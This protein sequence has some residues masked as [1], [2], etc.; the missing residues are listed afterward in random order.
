MKKNLFWITLVLIVA[1]LSTMFLVA[2]KDKGNT[3]DDNTQ[4][5]K[6][7]TEGFTPQKQVD[8]AIASLS[9][10]CNVLMAENAS[11]DISLANNTSD[12]EHSTELDDLFAM[13]DRNKSAFKSSGGEH[14]SSFLLTVF[15]VVLL[16]ALQ[17]HGTDCLDHDIA[18]S[19]IF[20]GGESPLAQDLKQYFPTDIRFHGTIEENGKNVI[21]ASVLMSIEDVDGTLTFWY[22]FKTYYV[23]DDHFGYSIL[24]APIS[25]PEY[26]YRAGDLFFYYDSAAPD[27]FLEIVAEKMG[28]QSSGSIQYADAVCKDLSAISQQDLQIMYDFLDYAHASFPKSDRSDIL[29]TIL[30]VNLDD[31]IKMS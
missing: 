7:P 11:A 13:L 26:D 30:T 4:Q 31:I 1:L 12:S 21:H 17:K 27:R 9:A 23:D 19:Y 24:R 3:G 18:A 8:I 22:D 15:S 5:S 28:G 25:E 14:S 10:I 2:C 6:P 20:N 29:S 16:D